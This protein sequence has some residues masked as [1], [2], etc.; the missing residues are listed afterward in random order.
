MRSFLVRK[1]NNFTKTLSLRAKVPNTYG[2]RLYIML[3]YIMLNIGR[4]YCSCYD[5]ILHYLYE[6]DWDSLSLC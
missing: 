1:I 4:V 6:D 5:I 3:L 2:A